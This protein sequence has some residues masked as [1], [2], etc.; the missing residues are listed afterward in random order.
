MRIAKTRCV[1]IVYANDCHVDVVVY[2][3]LADGREVIVN[4]DLDEWEDTNPQGFTAWMRTKD[5]IT[6]GNLRKVIRLLKYL[7]DHKETFAV[8]SVILTTLVGGVVDEGRKL[9]DPSHYADVP[10]TLRSI[11]TDLDEWLQAG[12][13]SP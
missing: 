8:K 2:L 5:D 3:K 11:L 6:A 1:R 9:L 10:T 12:R 7:R 4:S 13:S